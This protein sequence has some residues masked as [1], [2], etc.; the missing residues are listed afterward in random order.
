MVEG[1]GGECVRGG[2]GGKGREWE[3]MSRDFLDVLLRDIDLN[4]CRC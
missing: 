4:L 3:G 2:G 1:G